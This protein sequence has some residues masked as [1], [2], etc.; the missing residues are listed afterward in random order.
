MIPRSVSPNVSGW[1]RLSL[2]A[3]LVGGHPGLV[4]PDGLCLLSITLPQIPSGLFLCLP[5]AVLTD[6]GNEDSYIYSY[7]RAVVHSFCSGFSSIF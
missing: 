7:S 6:V 2:T 5:L 3:K 4:V 1:G